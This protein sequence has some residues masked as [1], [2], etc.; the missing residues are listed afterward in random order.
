M[1]KPPPVDD[2]PLDIVIIGASGDLARKKIIP[3][4]F[5]LYS[6]GLLPSHWNLYGY[7]RSDMSDAAFRELA[8]THLTCRYVPGEDCSDRMRE[9]LDRCRYVSGQYDAADDYLRLYQ[10]MRESSDPACTNRLFYLAIP[11][12]VFLDTARGLGNAGLV[13][14][15]QTEPWS[16]VVIEKPFGH[17]RA[18]SDALVAGLS[19]VFREAQTF[20][21]DHYLGKEV[22]QNLLVLRFANAM[23]EP[24]W[25]ADH[26]DSVR[27]DWQ[28]DHGVDGRGGY[29]DRYGVIRDVMQ[30]HLLQ[31]LSLVAMEQ[32]SRITAG[33]ICNEKV[34]VLRTVPPPP[35]TDVVVG[36]YGPARYRNREMPGYRDDKTVA[37]NSRTPTY[38]AAILRVENARWHGVPFFIQ[39]GKGL[40][41]R[42]T[43]IRIR[44]KVNAPPRFRVV[45]GDDH[46]AN[47]LVIRVQPDEGITMTMACKI[48]GLDMRIGRSSLD[49]SYHEAFSEHLIPDAYESLLIEVIR[50]ERSLFIRRDELAAAWDIFTPVLHAIDATAV[51][52]D[53]YPFG[54]QGP[55]AARA[56]A[57]R[58]GIRL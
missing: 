1:S 23:F 44:F 12:G 49:L 32:P 50:G 31:I 16:R 5:A 35:L 15:G 43:E 28:E 30:N 4:L 22:I 6:Q 7:A 20:R 19:H 25:N 46:F 58:C 38:A 8:A 51:T 47:E 54:S 24:I 21:I 2:R 56:L 29:Y 34:K 33:N 10:R 52:P 13:R 45:E 11:P 9:F 53:P 48:P 3:A 41:S 40:G 26:I 42:M 37:P 18:S 57:E 17:D 55:D 14:C 27:I 39:A 36:Q